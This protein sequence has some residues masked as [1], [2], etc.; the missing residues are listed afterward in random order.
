MSILVSIENLLSGNIVEGTRMEFKKGWNPKTIMRSVCAFAND[1]ENE[2]SGYIVV[3]VDEAEGKAIRPVLG[4]NPSDLE[5]VEK[6]LIGFCNLIKPT[7]M[8]RLSL[9]PID[10]KHVLVLWVPSGSNRAYKVPDDV[11]AKHKTYNYRI[12]YRSNSVIPNPEQEAELLQL[13]AKIPFDDRVNTHS[14][15]SDMSFSLMREHLEKT[16]S[17]LYQ[18]SHIM[19]V[20]QLAEKMNLSQGAD[21]HL[22]PKNVGLLM[23]SDTPEKYFKG[24]QIDIVEFPKGVAGKEFNEKIFHGAI[25]KQLV[26]VLSYIKTN[27]I[28]EKVIKYADKEA[29]DRVFNYP[30]NAIEEALSNAVYHRNYELLDPIEVRILP[31]AIEIISFN[32][33]DPSLK[34]RDFD[35]GIVRARRYRNRRIGEFLKELRLTEGRGTGIPTIIKALADNGS[36]E[37]KFDANEPERT[38]FLVEIPIHSAFYG[39]GADQV[40]DQVNKRLESLNIRELSEVE[41]L[42]KELKSSEWDQVRDQVSD[43]ADQVNKHLSTILE[44]CLKPKSR[45]EV[46]EKIGLANKDSNFK[47][48]AGEALDFNWIE[49]TSSTTSSDQKYVTT[50][51]GKKLIKS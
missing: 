19:T 44:Y 28:K 27:V 41:Q 48:Y 24:V 1:F 30:F 43:Q 12:R 14:N 49:M 26:D 2:G 6:Q 45:K 38:H 10:G 8:P 9:E 3:G 32:G 21:E 17:R 15:V 4:F 16:N 20:T 47:R 46:C 11:T 50:E 36:P 34:Q 39:P 18:D 22:F 33:A 23:F 13:T 35:K 40:R 25:Q 37:P 5:T 42:I 7:Y 29:S 31:E 51:K